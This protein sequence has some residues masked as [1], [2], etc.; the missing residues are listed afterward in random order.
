M[1]CYVADKYIIEGA[2]YNGDGTTSAEAASAGAAG[3]WNHIN[4]ITGT[5]VGYGTL[6][7]GDT[8]YIRSKTSAGAD[9]SITPTAIPTYMGVTTATAAAHINWVLDNGAIWS[10]IDGQLSFAATGD[11]YMYTRPFNNFKANTKHALRFTCSSVSKAGAMLVISDSE[12]EGAYVDWSATT[13][14]SNTGIHLTQTTNIDSNA[15]G[16]ANLR[17]SYI[18]AGRFSRVFTISGSGRNLVI[19]PEIEL[20][21]SATLGKIF[22]TTATHLKAIGGRVFGSGVASG[23]RIAEMP[24]DG[25]GSSTIQTYGLKIPAAINQHAYGVIVG[26]GQELQCSGLDESGKGSLF[27][28]YWG[29]ADSR[30]D[31]YYPTLSAT[32]PDSSS[33][34]WSWKIF[35][36]KA[37]V[38]FP[39]ELLVEKIYTDTSAT[40]TVTL[41]IALADT[42][43][44]DQSTIWV[45]VHYTDDA[46]GEQRMV[47]T[48]ST[49]ALTAST[50]T[51]SASTY[52]AVNLDTYK[53][54]VTTPT[55]IRQD[56]RVMAYL[57]ITVGSATDGDILFVC[58]DVQLS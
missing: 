14:T 25:N 24:S 3:A 21:S 51:W 13:G 48:R 18:K 44:A 47:T 50:A 1:G 16:K 17:S 41:E 6:A 4:I 49:G 22:Y 9:I 19:D 35:P 38:N 55:A 58:P 40:K 39:G 52:G 53:F 23:M 11:Y 46:S 43:S 33:T 54:S 10:G 37:S 8:V 27:A 12:I 5:A 32:Y 7:A 45:D 26:G 57:N 56:T 42:I 34:P 31:G 29:V 36:Y 30:D 28:G 20:T 15:R 2:T